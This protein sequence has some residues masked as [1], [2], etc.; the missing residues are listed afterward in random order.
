[1]N[2]FK[3]YAFYYD[4]L[5]QEKNYAVETTYIHSLIEQYA[6]KADKLL[7]LGCGTGK[8]ALEMV[9]RGYRVH[10]VDLSPEMLVQAKKNANIKGF[11]DERL[12]FSQGD[13]RSVR[14]DKKFDVAL[15][16]FH[17]MSYQTIPA[18]TKAFLNTMVDHLEVGGIL[19]F[20]CWYGPSIIADKPSICVKKIE[21]DNLYVTRITEPSLHVECHCVD[22]NFTLFVE[23]KDTQQIIKMKETH[24]MRYFFEEEIIALF[25]ELGI[26][27]LS[28][29]AWFTGGNPSEASRDVCVVGRKL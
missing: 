6:P 26:E 3:D 21:N 17:V 18:D 8:H 12:Q 29:E 11:D 20:D 23:N 1:M 10:G 14:L 9:N 19:I 5:Y 27:L 4:L 15:S 16:L 2:V 13:A 28:F 7:D 24:V 25:K 22:I